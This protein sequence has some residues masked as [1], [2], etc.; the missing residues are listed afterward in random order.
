[1]SQEPRADVIVAADS[2]PTQL[3]GRTVQ[4]MLVHGGAQSAISRLI[5]ITEDR[6]F[7]NIR[8]DLERLAA[9]GSQGYHS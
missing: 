9:D 7:G 3:E 4:A 8:C 1:M 6:A 2:D 5:V